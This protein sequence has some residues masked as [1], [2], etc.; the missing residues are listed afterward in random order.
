M[1]V[2]PLI[3]GRDQQALKQLVALLR[4]G[5]Q[6]ESLKFDDVGVSSTPT[7]V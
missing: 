2:F 4:R 5:E 1:T 7:G 6:V 3:R